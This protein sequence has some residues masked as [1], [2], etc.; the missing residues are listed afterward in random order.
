VSGGTAATNFPS[1][2]G[3][4]PFT[5]NTNAVSGFLTHF[6]ANGSSL[7]YS[8][9][10]PMVGYN[11]ALDVDSAGNAVVAGETAIASLAVGVAAFQP[12]Y[13]GGSGD[14]YILRFTPDGRVSGS[15]YLG[16]SLAETLTV[17][18]FGS[19]GSVVVSG[20]TLS[21]DFPGI[22]P[23][24]AFGGVTFVTSI[25]PSL[26]VLN[27][28]SYVA[29]QVA[30]GEIVALK[31][32]GIGPVNGIVASGTTL[33][34]SLGGVSIAF[35]GIAAPL[36]YVQAEQ[37]NAQVPWEIAGR[38]LTA[39]TATFPNQPQRITTLLVAASSLPGIFHVNNADGSPNSPTNPA[40]PGDL[41]SLYGTGGGS[42][43]PPGLTGQFWG[44]S[45]PL[46]TLTL[47]VL[48]TLNGEDAAV[49]YAGSAPTLESGIFQVNALVPPDAVAS[50]TGSVVLTIGGVASVAV[51]IAIT[52]P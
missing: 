18:A 24:I 15:T 32:Y 5:G 19:N 21:P 49:S 4:P 2:S 3:A 47:P 30:P 25:F 41:I 48:V 7:I 16:G 44:L 1:T 22:T 45:V 52:V 6:S 37:I 9:F 27:A 36:L 33:P 35:D 14:A 51:P 42:A 46:S 10:L 23:P 28:A 12:Q 11:E 20:N 8:T 17:I 29:T 13:A 39:L 31:G 26:T 38:T 43:S 50:A 34:T 40:H